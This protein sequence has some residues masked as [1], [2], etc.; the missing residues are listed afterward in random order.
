VPSAISPRS[1]AAHIT[2]AQALPSSSTQLQPPHQHIDQSASLSILDRPGSQEDAP[3]DA[4]DSVIATTKA[5]LAA[6]SIA[7]KAAKAADAGAGGGCKRQGGRKK[8]SAPVK[9]SQVKGTPTRKAATPAPTST[10]APPLPAAGKHHGT[11]VY[12]NCR[13]YCAIKT[14]K[15]RVQVIGET[16]DRQFSWSSGRAAVWT[17]VLAYCRTKSR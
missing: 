17:D 12:K 10:A 4:V 16:Y 2:S 3:A 13:I 6:K 9:K 15:W 1:A 5:A 11:I 14:S 7:T 8:A